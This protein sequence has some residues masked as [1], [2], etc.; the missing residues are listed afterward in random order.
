[1]THGSFFTQDG[2]VTLAL[3]IFQQEKNTEKEGR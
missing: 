2:H 1:M 3:E